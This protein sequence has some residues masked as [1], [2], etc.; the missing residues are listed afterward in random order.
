MGR[1]EEKR[2]ALNPK[3]R[4]EIREEEGRGGEEKRE[5][6]AQLRRSCAMRTHTLHFPPLRSLSRR[7]AAAAAAKEDA[8][9][10]RALAAAIATAPS[11]AP[12]G[13]EMLRLVCVGAGRRP[14]LGWLGCVWFRK[15]ILGK[16]KKK[17][18]EKKRG[19]RGGK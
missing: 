2:G 13:F 17:K 8:D 4:R 3:P 12:G 6:T 7:A 9:S 15:V 5:W 14:W 19:W 18:K 16:K 1:Q 10:S 11:S